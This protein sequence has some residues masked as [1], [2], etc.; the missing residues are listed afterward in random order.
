MSRIRQPLRRS[1]CA[2]AVVVIGALLGSGCGTPRLDGSLG[3]V[4]STTLLPMMSA[5]AGSFAGTNPLV[6]VDLRM[7]GTGEGLGLF[8]DGLAPVSGASRPMSERER[9]ACAAS[10]VH[11]VRLRVADDAVVLFTGDHPLPSC[12][13][14]DQIYALI[15][16]ESSAVETWSAA[17]TVI[18]DA[19]ASFPDVPLM[20]SGPGTGSGTRRVLVDLVIAP[21]AEQ[22]GVPA[23]LR[24]DYQAISSEQ[25]IAEA[26]APTPGGL[27]FAGFATL[28][29][30][31]GDLRFLGI[32]TGSGCVT[33]SL[34][35]I[36]DGSYPLGR[37][38]Y[39]YVNLT[40]VRADPTLTAFVDL[41][42][43]EQGLEAAAT[44]GGVAL[45]PATAARVRDHWETA[46]ASG[47]GDSR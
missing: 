27:G 46:L 47:R 20:V 38:L 25:L 19:G 37:P 10:G 15:G 21:L 34:D 1:L 2:A 29:A 41:V 44:S 6:R 18:P 17:S 33:P 11:F 13:T 39:L 32:D 8:C 3:I 24:S 31:Q 12:L 5:V 14:D 4:G 28:A 35:T 9:A 45:D 7:R 16:P 23:E 30:R 36:R 26:V 40:A 22:R 43:S 42:V